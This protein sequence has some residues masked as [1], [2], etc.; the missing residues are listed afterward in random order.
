[1]VRLAIE[2]MKH[3]R[4]RVH[5]QTNPYY[6]YSSEKTV[7]NA[8]RMFSSPR[9]RNSRNLTEIKTGIVQLFQH[10][11]PGFNL[12]R[13]SIKIPSAWE[14]MMTCHTLE[15]AGVLTLATTLFSML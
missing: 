8:L 12:D 9:K 10:V 7:I 13:I 1:M 4:G 3:I 2:M 14:G 11:Q 15:L 5:V 6:S